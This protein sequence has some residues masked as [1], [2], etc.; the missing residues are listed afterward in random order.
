LDRQT[1]SAGIG[2]V[3]RNGV[4][5]S[6]VPGWTFRAAPTIPLWRP[7]R[8]Q[9]PPSPA[10]QPS[11]LA[12][13]PRA[14]RLG[15]AFVRPTA[16]SAGAD[17][18]AALTRPARFRPGSLP[19]TLRNR[20]R[21]SDERER[22]RPFEAPRPGDENPDA[23]T[24]RVAAIQAS[25]GCARRCAAAPTAAS[26]R[27]AGGGES[28]AGGY[29][30]GQGVRSPC[31]A[32]PPRSLP[33][34]ATAPG[35]L[36]AAASAIAGRSLPALRTPR[37]RPFSRRLRLA[38]RLPRLWSL[39]HAASGSALHPTPLPALGCTP[40]TG[41]IGLEGFL[42]TGIAHRWPRFRTTETSTLKQNDKTAID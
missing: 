12:P 36:P 2:R 41:A 30:M 29:G 42:D 4:V 6:A 38:N 22:D 18:L 26:T 15:A 5:G 39:G 24:E 27:S 3:A 33:Y 9:P 14:G 1:A 37:G 17:C 11:C 34:S 28:L 8:S 40:R 23:A 20:R 35:A 16:F 31:R 19:P 21:R 25:N 7:A 13:S 32:K 10:P